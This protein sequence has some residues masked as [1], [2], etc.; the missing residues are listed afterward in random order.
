[1][2]DALPTPA[3][4]HPEVAW[5][6]EREKRIRHALSILGP[7][8]PTFTRDDMRAAV[9]AIDA[10]GVEVVA[11]RARLKLVDYVCHSHH[12]ADL[13][14]WEGTCPVCAEHGGADFYIENARLYR[15]TR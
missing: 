2:T 10:L 5:D 1:M 8:R 4:E 6:A 15:G 14:T 3:V 11:L 7:T 9:D 12:A 13:T